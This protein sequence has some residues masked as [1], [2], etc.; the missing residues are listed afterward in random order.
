MIVE[1]AISDRRRLS[2]LQVMK[3]VAFCAV[4]SACVAPMWQLWRLGVVAG[5]ILQGLVAV[6]LLEGVLVPLVGVALSM[7]LVRRGA[8]R[9]G[10]IFA[11][12]LWSASMALGIAWW[13][14]F[15]YTI[16]AYGTPDGT[17]APELAMHVGVIVALTAAALFLSVR[18][19]TDYRS[20]RRR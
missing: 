3:L 8:W 4:A 16:P 2:L 1:S 17:G 19:W 11:L 6:G 13:L 18:L 9:D 20:S 15:S 12:L 5:G 7:V 10:L 14:L